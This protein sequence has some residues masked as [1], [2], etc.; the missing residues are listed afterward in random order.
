VDPALLICALMIGS[1]MPRII[2]AVTG[3]LGSSQGRRGLLVVTP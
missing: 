1:V 3:D 2:A